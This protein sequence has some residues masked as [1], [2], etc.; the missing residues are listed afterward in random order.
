MNILNATQPSSFPKQVIIFDSEK[1]RRQSP[2]SFYLR[3]VKA[4]GTVD[5][6]ELHDASTL[7]EARQTAVSLAYTPTH[8]LESAVGVPVLF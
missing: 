8:W 1:A 4:D 6:V 3:V 2:D 5:A 7:V